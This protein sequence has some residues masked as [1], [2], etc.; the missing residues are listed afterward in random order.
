MTGIVEQELGGK[1]IGEVRG[2]KEILNLFCPYLPYSL[3]FLSSRL[4]GLG[5]NFRGCAQGADDIRGYIFAAT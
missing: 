4:Q 2:I 5:Y 1:E 3:Y